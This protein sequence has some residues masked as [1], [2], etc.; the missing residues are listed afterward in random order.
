M[1]TGAGPERRD[2]VRRVAD[3]LRLVIGRFAGTTAPREVFEGVVDDL[4]AIAE[5]LGRYEQAP[6]YF[7]GYGEAA[8]A[9]DGDGSFDHSPIMGLSNPLA[10]PIRFDASTKDRII[11]HVTFGAAYEGPPGCVHGGF[12]AAAFDEVL[13]L[14]QSLGGTP[15]MTGR[16]TIH[17]RSPTPLH[18]ELRME[19]DLVRVDGRKT[20]CSGR[21]LAGDVLCAEAEGLFIALSPE[22]KARLGLA[23]R[24]WE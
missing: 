12:I 15:G 2:E 24:A 14:A 22:T 11:G 23:D 20:I 16:L 3:A 7:D 10:P 13:G 8:I 6:L 5:R 4:G 21:I 18:T 9:G 1:T 19:G 17:Y